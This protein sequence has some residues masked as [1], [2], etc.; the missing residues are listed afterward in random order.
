MDAILKGAINNFESFKKNHL[1]GKPGS[2]PF[3]LFNDLKIW[4]WNHVLDYKNFH[5]K[6]G[7]TPLADLAVYQIN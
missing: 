7:V 1:F 6:A 3:N 4:D 5:W 2:S